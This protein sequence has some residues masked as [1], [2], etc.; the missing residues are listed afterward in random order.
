[1]LKS[2]SLNDYKN[3]TPNRS[4][5]IKKYASYMDWLKGRGRKCEC[6]CHSFVLFNPAL[7]E[8]IENYL[9]QHKECECYKK[10][11]SF[12]QLKNL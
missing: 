2:S 10:T 6:S 7:I 11:I 8:L 12:N 3:V 5:D 4:Y 9:Q 1:M